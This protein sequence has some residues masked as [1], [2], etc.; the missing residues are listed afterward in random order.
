[1]LL[2]MLR[3]AWCRNIRVLGAC[4]AFFVDLVDPKNLRQIKDLG[5][6]AGRKRGGLS[7]RRLAIYAAVA[8]WPSYR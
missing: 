6:A 5:L 3:L 8:Y 1:M 4:P 7:T 2:R